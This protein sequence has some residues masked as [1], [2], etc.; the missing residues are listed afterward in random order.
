M[1]IF[2]IDPQEGEAQDDAHRGGHTEDGVHGGV[3]S[4]LF[5]PL[6]CPVLRRLGPVVRPRDGVTLLH[7]EGPGHPGVLAHTQLL[8]PWQH[9]HSLHHGSL[10][11]PII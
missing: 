5:Y 9:R 3:D 4:G 2:D 1:S 7:V 6:V 10:Y 11:S 8:L